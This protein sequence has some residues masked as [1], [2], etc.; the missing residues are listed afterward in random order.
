MAPVETEET[1]PGETPD[2]AGCGL[3]GARPLGVAVLPP[4]PPDTSPVPSS[5]A[6]KKRPPAIPTVPPP[7]PPRL[8]IEVNNH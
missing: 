8:D 1:P 5:V 3:G 4:L 6:A 7:P 2:P